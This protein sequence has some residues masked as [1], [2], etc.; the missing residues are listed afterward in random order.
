MKL[1][2]TDGQPLDASWT[3]TVQVTSYRS[4]GTVISTS[5]VTIP[6]SDS[7][8]AG[9]TVDAL[10][11]NGTNAATRVLFEVVSAQSSGSSRTWEGTQAS[12]EVTK[13][14]SGSC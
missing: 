1:Y 13:P 12:G 9:H 7:G 5:P 11:A 3:V 2:G 8:V 10:A 4:N 6:V 14:N